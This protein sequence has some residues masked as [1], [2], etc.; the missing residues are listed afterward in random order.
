MELWELD[1]ARSQTNNLRLLAEKAEGNDELTLKVAFVNQLVISMAQLVR[2][3][4]ESEWAKEQ[5]KRRA[6]L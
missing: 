1:T 2:T 3:V 5:A 6:S 4:E